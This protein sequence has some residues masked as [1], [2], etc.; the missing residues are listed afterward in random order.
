MA[1]R[2]NSTKK[3]SW[4]EIIWINNK[5]RIRCYEATSYPATLLNTPTS[6]VYSSYFTASLFLIELHHK[7]FRSLSPKYILLAILQYCATLIVPSVLLIQIMKISMNK[8]VNKWGNCSVLMK[9]IWHRVLFA[10]YLCKEIYIP[11]LLT[12]VTDHI[13]LFNDFSLGGFFSKGNKEIF[14]GNSRVIF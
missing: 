12:Q 3:W 7:A 13:L 9:T 10:Q 14:T 6:I 1:L 5:K 11:H 8:Q 2:C 4:G